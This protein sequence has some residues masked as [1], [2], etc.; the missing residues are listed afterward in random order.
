MQNLKSKNHRIF[1]TS[2]FIQEIWRILCMKF[3]SIQRISR[4]SCQK[5][6]QSNFDNF[7]CNKIQR[8]KKIEKEY[9]NLA[10]DVESNP[11]GL[12][13][14]NSNKISDAKIQGDLYA[15]KWLMV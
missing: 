3:D 1:Q 11:C 14:F 15:G 13:K 2:P 10:L 7:W 9:S 12:L 4:V 6:S 5:Y 8:R